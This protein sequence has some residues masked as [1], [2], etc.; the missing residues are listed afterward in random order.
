MTNRR[1]LAILALFANISCTAPKDRGA[2]TTD[3]DSVVTQNAEPSAEQL[4][5]ETRIG[6][7]ALGG[8][9]D[10]A[11]ATRTSDGEGVAL[12]NIAIN[13]DTIIAYL[14]E[15]DPST[16]IDLNKP[17]LSMETMSPRF[18][19][20]QGV[21]AGSLITD[22]EKVYGKTRVIGKSEIESREFITFENQP[23]YL[24]FRI[25]AGSGVF[26]NDSMSTTRFVPGSRIFSISI[27]K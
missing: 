14:G 25:D 22:V 21:H 16:P 17:I 15:D 6:P 26:E 18:L 23:A 19:T 13:G 1:Y 27:R 24:N 7:V 20:D 12:V 3:V 2:D 9:V 8:R 5:T 4:I 10:S 11:I